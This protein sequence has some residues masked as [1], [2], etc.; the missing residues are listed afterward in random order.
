MRK[1]VESTMTKV[2]RALGKGIDALSFGSGTFAGII[3]LIAAIITCYEIISRYVF[4]SPTVWTLEVTI[5]ILIWFGFI[6][7]A[8][9]QREGRHIHLDILINRFSPRSR[10]I[11][12]IVT[13]VVT[14]F[15][16]IIFIYYSYN[17]FL[18]AV[19]SHETTLGIFVA[20][21]WL[22]KLALFAGGTLLGLQLVKDIV[23]K[24][25]TLQ[26]QPVEKKQGLKDNPIFFIVIFLVMVGVGCWLYQLSPLGGLMVLM[27]TLLFAGVPIF[28]AL[29]L[30]GIVGLFSVYGGI[31]ALSAIPNVSFGALYNFALACLPLFIIAGQILVDSGTGD[32]LYDLCDK[33]LGHFPGGLAVATI[34][35]CAIF[36]AISISS[37]VVAITIG[38]VA[39]PAL[40]A[41]Q[42]N[43]RF[44]YGVL[45]AGATLG[46]MIPPSGTMI[47]YSAVTEESLGKLFI[48]GFIP[49]LILVAMFTI[50]T[51]FFCARAGRYERVKPY[52]WKQRLDALKTATWGLLVPIIIIAG[53]YTGIFTVLEAGAVVAIYALIMALARRKIKV[54]QLP[55]VLKDSAVNGS[56]ILVIIA[57]ALIMGLFMTLLQVP[58][59]V[60][61]FITAAHIPGWAVI[62][63]LMVGYIILGMF[64]E[65]LAVMMITLPVVYPLII[66]LGFDGIWFAVLVTLNMEMALITPPVGMNLYIVKGISG[67]PITE[68]VR[69]VLPFFVIMLIGLVI[70]AIFPQLSTWLPG[71]MVK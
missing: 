70:F 56:L 10:A 25:N 66:S 8:C 45:T 35:T 71:L 52:T 59:T 41:H 42:Y 30:A 46:I 39:L 55:N 31:S 34:M 12:D 57:G 9:A 3:M 29:A 11:W 16:I 13:M 19:K 18:A 64:L 43:K 37:L 21:M 32:E 33:W 60:V 28:A 24:S 15:F 65:V 44:S 47:I 40:A 5:F 53:I 2:A 7:M 69:G 49:G 26:T 4:N 22:P 68:V 50:Y 27:L 62:A 17:F 51:I 61:N 48:A 6:A 54:S 14:L 58:N 1:L 63:A 20:P 23:V 38:L 67:A 36:A